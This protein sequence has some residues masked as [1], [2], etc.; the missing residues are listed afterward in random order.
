MNMEA[1]PTRHV[2]VP[3]G[4]ITHQDVIADDLQ[5]CIK[6]I[7]LLQAMYES[8][9]PEICNFTLLDKW[10]AS[11]ESR[12]VFL[13]KSSTKFGVVSEGC[14][15]AAYICCY[16]IYT[17]IWRNSFIPMKLAERLLM[18][19][20]K[21]MS[22]SI[23]LRRRD[24]FLWLAFVCT[25]I[26]QGSE[27]NYYTATAKNAHEVFMRQLSTS[28]KSWA[29]RRCS[30]NSALSEYIYVSNWL[31]LRLSNKLWLAIEVGLHVDAQESF[32]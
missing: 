13:T 7:L 9:D 24:V 15:L 3:N 29:N 23:W 25:S 6:D 18:H 5:D 12:L 22:Y 1:I 16:S 11:I 31:Q 14:R 27:A 32:Q 4:F 21:T 2:A 17:E 26:I 28:A 20:S 19:L 30:I 8:R 10:Q